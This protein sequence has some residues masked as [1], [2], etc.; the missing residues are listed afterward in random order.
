MHN[1]ETLDIIIGVV[2]DCELKLDPIDGSTR[3]VAKPIPEKILAMIS[4]Y[5]AMCEPIPYDISTFAHTYL[6]HKKVDAL[7]IMGGALDVDPKYYGEKQEENVGYSYDSTNNTRTDF[8]LAV[9]KEVEQYNAINPGIPVLG[10]CNGMQ[11]MWVHFGGKMIQHIPNNERV[12]ATGHNIKHFRHTTTEPIPEHEIRFV[13]KSSCLSSY[14]ANDIEI[15]PSTHHQAVDHTRQHMLRKELHSVAEASDGVIELYESSCGMYLGAQFHP[16][17]NIDS[18]LTADIM[19]HIIN[20]AKRCKS[21][22][23]QK[24]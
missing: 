23:L 21:A 9:L 16:E 19:N 1:F 24:K 10:I 22:D 20:M 17:F 12:K 2:P 5:G 6:A 14:N 4:H 13:R 8:E 15:V 18:K 7:L 3:V 11:T